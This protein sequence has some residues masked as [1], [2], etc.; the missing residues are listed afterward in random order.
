MTSIAWIGTGVMGASMCRHLLNAGHHVTVY[1]RSREKAEPLIQDGATWAASPLEAAQKA[2]VTF[3]MVGFPADVREVY[4]GKN[5]VLAG[6]R[7]GS[8]VV[9][10]TSTSPSLAVEIHRQAAP[11][12]VASLD[13][14][15]SGGDV[16][17]RNAA[18]SIMVGGDPATFNT[19]L[20]LFEKMGKT[21][22]HQ[23]PAGAGQHTKLCNQIVVA[24]TIIGVCESLFYG[25]RAGLNLETML[26]S[27][28]GGAAACWTLD[29]LAPRVLKGNFD[30]G[31]FVDHFVK[32]MALVL[33]ES[34]RMNINLPG[35][36]VVHDV[37]KRVQELGHGQKGTHALYLALEAMNRADR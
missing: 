20:P 37:Y 32:D 22:I 21:I 23:G 24:G 28:R 30:P 31:F 9:D 2:D 14:P 4:F 1:S 6:A 17:A 11:G 35:L 19:V 8:I 7:R 15:V 12:G 36:R 10:M 26:Q 3:T 16:G 5:G 29:N 34:A 13:A 18:L 25:K 27:I 33:E